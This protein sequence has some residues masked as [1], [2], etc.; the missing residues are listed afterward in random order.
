MAVVATTIVVNIMMYS[1]TISAQPGC[2][3]RLKA[4]VKLLKKS[5]RDLKTK[6]RNGRFVVKK[7]KKSI[8]AN[9]ADFATRANHARKATNAQYLANQNMTQKLFF[10]GYS[11]SQGAPPAGIPTRFTALWG[12]VNNGNTF[13]FQGI[14]PWRTYDNQCH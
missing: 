7:S 2:C 14:T 4:Q 13:V 8:K 1:T 11:C 6:L 3:R 12:M 10:R 5:L 9:M